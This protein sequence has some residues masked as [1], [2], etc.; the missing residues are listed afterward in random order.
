MRARNRK[1]GAFIKGT[2]ERVDAAADVLPDHFSRETS[3]KLTHE[4][5]KT[6]RYQVFW[7]THTPVINAQGQVY[8]DDAGNR[9]NADDV[10][11][12]GNTN[13]GWRTPAAAKQAKTDRVVRHT[14]RNP[15]GSQLTPDNDPL[16]P[17]LRRIEKLG[18][19]ALE[20]LQS[21]SMALGQEAERH[22]ELPPSAFEHRLAHE[23]MI[24]TALMG[25]ATV[26]FA[27]PS[28][29]SGVFEA[30]VQIG[31]EKLTAIKRF[32][33]LMGIIEGQI[34]E[35][36]AFEAAMNKERQQAAARPQLTVLAGGRSTEE[37]KK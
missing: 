20:E 7:D 25:A 8:I 19:E 29:Q 36:E 31:E 13:D 35:E 34:R 27:D 37:P 11:I 33:K 17:H 9:V 16:I 12:S 10:E 18:T 28:N 21:Y 3:G 32:R 23:T 2:I 6:T 4:H 22:I 30:V 14:P 5:D 15:V 26:W 1:T 24:A